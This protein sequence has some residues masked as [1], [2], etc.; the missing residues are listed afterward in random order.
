MG[1]YSEFIEQDIKVVNEFGLVLV[2]S[3]FEH[4]GLVREDG[5]VD[6]S[7]WDGNKIEGYWYP[8]TIKVLKDI[9]PFIVGYA[10]FRYEEGFEFKIIFRDGKVFYNRSEQVW[11]DESELQ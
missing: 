10:H 1:M 2:A 7:E 5:E 9:A 6:F 4:E 11:G 8:E 3:Q